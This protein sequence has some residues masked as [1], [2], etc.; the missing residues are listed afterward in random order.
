MANR[1]P[2]SFLLNQSEEAEADEVV[3]APAFSLTKVLTTGVGI[4]AP[5]TAGVAD[6]IKQGEGLTSEHWVA[7]AIGLLGFLAII[8]SADVIGRSLATAAEK[9]AQAAAAGMSQFAAFQDPISAR[10][11][12]G[13]DTE[14]DPDVVLLAVAQADGAHYLVKE[15]ESIK[16]L[17][18]SGIE[19]GDKKP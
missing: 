11:I 15:G 14:P 13:S 2:I 12:L 10:R 18:A 6:W 8:A 19:I 17:P 1:D 16:W 3:E 9:N 4:V 7:L 5:I